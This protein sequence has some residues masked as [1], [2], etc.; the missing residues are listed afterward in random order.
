MTAEL[1]VSKKGE[2]QLWIMCDITK[3]INGF[4][5]IRLDNFYDVR[6]EVLTKT[7][8]FIK[9]M[10]DK[11]LYYVRK[12][13]LFSLEIVYPKS[14]TLAFIVDFGG[15]ISKGLGEDIEEFSESLRC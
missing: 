10:N 13:E 9:K 6:R 15:P 4:G 11:H 8:D 12:Y 1:R 2:A 3:W 14:K 5:E 7:W